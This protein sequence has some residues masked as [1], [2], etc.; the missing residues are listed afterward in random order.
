[1]TAD[2]RDETAVTAAVSGAHAALGGL[3]GLVNC[4]GV[5]TVNRLEDTTLE[6]WRR[7]IDTNMTGVFLFCRAATPLL[8]ASG[9][10]SI[11]NLASASG[12]TPSFA[13]AAYGATK[14]GVVMLSKS[15]ARELAPSIRVN[16]V[17]PGIVDTPMFEAMTGADAAAI[18]AI[19]AGYA[20]QRLARPEEIAEA[21]AFLSGPRSAF[22][23]GVAL[24][25]DGGRSFH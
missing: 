9:D 7:L 15:L 14:A 19:K 17:C 21:V 5:A 13:G 20:L 10:G 23:T 8:R 25:V 4:A 3:D 6:E 1:M 2:V 12:L 11:V 24:A 22:I 16:V 18:S